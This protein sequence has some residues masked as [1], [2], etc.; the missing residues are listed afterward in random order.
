MSN[1]KKVRSS[2]YNFKPI[3]QA[4]TD[5]MYKYFEEYDKQRDFLQRIQD[6]Q[7]MLLPKKDRR[8]KLDFETYFRNRLVEEDGFYPV[9]RLN[10]KG[11]FDHYDMYNA[12][13][14]AKR[15]FDRGLT[16]EQLSREDLSNLGDISAIKDVF[17]ENFK[18]WEKV[19]KEGISR[20]LFKAASQGKT[21]EDVLKQLVEKGKGIPGRLNK[22]IDA[23]FKFQQLKA[24]ND[25]LKAYDPE[26]YDDFVVKYEKDEDGNKIP[27]TRKEDVERQVKDLED[28]IAELEQQK[29][30]D[31][32]FNDRMSD[33]GSFP[34]VYN[35]TL[36]GNAIGVFTGETN[37][38]KIKV[39]QNQIQALK[40]RKRSELANVKRIQ[41]GK[42]VPTG[43]NVK[44]ISNE[45]SGE[46]FMFNPE[47]D[48][49]M[50]E[51]ISQLKYL[52]PTED[53]T[54]E[55]TLEKYNASKEYR[56]RNPVGGG[57]AS[58][59]T[60][61]L[62]PYDYLAH[63]LQG[64]TML[65]DSTLGLDRRFNNPL[66]GALDFATYA[67]PG[68]SVLRGA[69]MAGNT[70]DSVRDTL[71]NSNNDS[72]LL[73]GL[74]WSAL[75]AL[76]ASSLLSPLGKGFLRPM[77]KNTRGIN[78]NYQI[79]PKRDNVSRIINP[80]MKDLKSI[81]L[82]GNR[83]IEYGNPL[84]EVKRNIAQNRIPA[85]PKD[86]QVSKNLDKYGQQYVD[87]LGKMQSQTSPFMTN[88]WA[89]RGTFD[90]LA[91][92]PLFAKSFVL[93]EDLYGRDLPKEFVNPQK[94]VTQKIKNMKSKSIMR[95]KN[96]KNYK[97]GGEL[98]KAQTGLSGLGRS[99]RSPISG[100]G[101]GRR[102]VTIKDIKNN[103]Q[104]YYPGLIKYPTIILKDSAIQRMLN[105]E[106]IAKDMS[107]SNQPGWSELQEMG[108]S[109]AVRALFDQNIDL[110]TLAREQFNKPYAALTPMESR[111]LQDKVTEQITNFAGDSF[112]K[113]KTVST[114]SDILRRLK[115]ET[116]NKGKTSLEDLRFVFNAFEG[117]RSGELYNESRSV[118]ERALNNSYSNAGDV[119]NAKFIHN[120]EVELENLKGS[121][122]NYFSDELSLSGSKRLKEYMQTGFKDDINYLKTTQQLDSS[123]Y[124]G[125]FTRDDFVGGNQ[126]FAKYFQG[127]Q[128]DIPEFGTYRGFD[129]AMDIAGGGFNNFVV[130]NQYPDQMEMIAK[131]KKEFNM[132]AHSA[133]PLSVMVNDLN[134]S[135]D[136]YPLQLSNNLRAVKNAEKAGIFPNQVFMG[137]RDLNSMDFTAQILRKKLNELRMKTSNATG[138][139]RQKLQEQIDGVTSRS[140][141]IR[142]SLLEGKLNAMYDKA[143]ISQDERLPLL[144]N[145]SDPEKIFAPQFGIV[146]D[147][148]IFIPPEERYMYK[149]GGIPMAQ[150]GIAGVGVT[151]PMQSMT[152]D[153]VL[154]APN[155]AGVDFSKLNPEQS[156]IAQSADFREDPRA[157][158]G[159]VPFGVRRQQRKANKKLMDSGMGVYGIPFVGTTPFDRTA[160]QKEQEQQPVMENNT[161]GSLPK[162]NSYLHTG[163]NKIGRALLHPFNPD[164]RIHDKFSN[165]KFTRWSGKKRYL[166]DGGYIEAELTEKEILDLAKQGYIIE[167]M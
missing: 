45:G 132:G 15:I 147:P 68:V 67:L 40:D 105:M 90:K 41:S 6:A 93:N 28:Q 150:V 26:T 122:S 103:L 124:R 152:P 14:I 30:V 112:K 9:P 134:L 154:P 113:R 135:A 78:P 159:Q 4:N 55:S 2:K 72:D 95:G 48:L 81:S 73:E 129:Q 163:A 111:E 5:Q 1:P 57:L 22:F 49:T 16:A 158:R 125:R 94:P 141:Q 142:A 165:M 109:P 32:R 51:K 76:G 34:S 70:I 12:D 82:P 21:K 58:N 44:T 128:F 117:G 101:G 145:D 80:R 60:K 79:I 131:S 17:G 10:E 8:P 39:L 102:P 38:E 42:A 107:Y 130:A 35:P 88:T 23:P 19:Y 148:N 65:E 87:Y 136:S 53:P 92:Q 47:R 33:E 119:D 123:P 96:L 140:P 52:S 126:P 18:G 137:Y 156:A 104:S 89:P 20:D 110:N 162:G 84:N 97:E 144:M 7:D 118:L 24:Y 127:H 75:G 59:F 74:G 77:G 164:K 46:D 64:T 36:G 83:R 85:M 106:Q 54:K 157:F 86:V 116:P 114:V 63:K 56:K 167:D 13:K 133:S 100:G 25:Y 43:R 139:E 69:Q 61:I 31:D 120:L 50:A 160:K 98:L 108:N 161:S 71:Q 29:I 11:E 99:Y 153:P 146:K 166:D 62:H 149:R 115:A 143:R 37:D 3:G 155:Y 121:N 27:V 66:T 138:S 91:L 151:N